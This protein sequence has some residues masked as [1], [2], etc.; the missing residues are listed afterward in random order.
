MFYL[1]ISC[2]TIVLTKYLWHAFNEKQFEPTH[3]LYK[4]ITQKK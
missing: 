1:V 4:A 2:P 3:N